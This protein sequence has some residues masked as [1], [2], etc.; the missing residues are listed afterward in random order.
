MRLKRSILTLTLLE[1]FIHFVKGSTKA[2][3]LHDQR[4]IFRK[5]LDT[6]VTD[7]SSLILN[8]NSLYQTLANLTSNVVVNITTN[9]TL[10]T[11]VQLEDLEN[12]SIIGH[13]KPFIEC[14][15][16][17]G[18]LHFTSC[19]NCTIEGIIWKNCGHVIGNKTY[20]VLA[21]YKS[22]TVTIQD[23]SFENSAAQAVTLSEVSGNITVANCKFGYNY[24][25]IYKGHG[26]AVYY[27]KG[28]E[29]HL[30]FTI[31][32][33]DFAHFGNV[34]SVVYIGRS[35]SDTN[36]TFLLHNSTFISNRGVPIYFLN[37]TL[38]ISGT[39]I[40]KRNINGGIFAS[41]SNIMIDENSKVIFYNNVAKNGGAI[42]LQNHSLI[43]FKN[44]S[45]VQ[46]N[47]NFA[48]INGGAI[49]AYNESK[50]ILEG[51]SQVTFDNNVAV[52]G[53]GGAVFAM[54]RVNITFTGNCS[55]LFTNNK[56]VADSK[57]ARNGGAITLK[58]HSSITFEGHCD[59][60]LI[61]NSAKGSGGAI[62]SSNSSC[63]TFQ[64]KSTVRFHLNEAKQG[65]AMLSSFSS[66]IKF[67][68]NTLVIYSAN[69]AA[70]SNSVIHTVYNA[71]DTLNENTTISESA[72]A[73]HLQ[74][75]C[76]ITFEGK[77]LV[78][79]SYHKAVYG[80]T[81]YAYNNS[82]VT[83]KGNATVVFDYNEAEFGGAIYANRN[84]DISI[85][86]KSV[87]FI[88]N[89]ATQDGGALYSHDACDITFKGKAMVI[90]TLDK[91]T[92]NGGVGYF[93][94]SCH[95]IFEGNTT[96]RFDN[97]EAT[98]EAGVLYAAE[99][100]VEF[101]EN[102]NIV[103]DN[104][105]AILSGGALYFTNISN[106]SF[107]ENSNTTFSNNRATFNGGA[108]YFSN[109]SL[110]S[111]SDTSQVMFYHNDAL[112]GGAVCYNNN[113]SIEFKDSSAVTFIGN[114]ATVSGGAIQ[115]LSNSDITLTSNNTIIFTNNTAQYGGAIFFD[116]TQSSMIFSNIQKKTITFINNNAR[117]IGNS[118]Y[119]DLMKSCNSSCLANRIVGINI[120]NISFIAT[121][122]SKLMLYDPAICIDDDNDSDC[123][124]YYL[125]N[126]MF[127][128]DIVVPT[129][130]LD[131]YNQK[132]VD[133][134]QFLVRG[135]MNQN[136]FIKGPNEVL[137]S[138]D[139]FK[140]ISIFGNKS[141]SRSTNHT[142]TI[143]LNVD[144]NS[145]WKIISVNLIVELS[146]CHPGFQ[147]DKKLQECE[148]YNASDIVL[149]SGSTSSIKGG[150]WFGS[151]TG[152]PTVTFC[153]INYCNFS[154]CDTANGFYHLSPLRDN[155][156][157]SRRSG[158]AC[159]SCTDGY[160]LSFDSTD[161]VPVN[162]CTAGHTILIVT[163]TLI[164]WIA[165]V[166]IVFV[167]MHYKVSIGYLYAVTF[168]YSIVDILLSQ[169][170]YVS[171][172][173]FMTVNIM[174]STAKLTPQFL[175]QLCLAKD[176]S[177]ID[178]QV[179]HYIH[180]LAVSFILLIISFL[181]RCSYRLSAFIS[182]E[183]I[184]VICFL[185]L[186]SYTSLA[187]TSLMLL[188]SLTFVDVDTVYTYLSPDIE[189][190]HGRHLVYAIT[191]ILFMIS[192][193]AGLPLLLSLEPFVNG[194]INFTKI[195][196]L[197]DQFQ[198]CYKDRYRCFAG[199]YMICRLVIILII[200]SNSSSYFSNQYLL[201]ATCSMIALL[202]L[203]VR[204]Y[205]DNMLNVLDGIVLQLLV[206]ITALPLLDTYNSNTGLGITFTL[207]VSPVLS[208]L[209]VTLV[210]RRED[211]KKIVIYCDC[212][213]INT[214]NNPE[215]PASTN[216][217]DDN[218]VIKRTKTATNDM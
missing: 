148:C 60:N 202:H 131:Y 6:K 217:L 171:P 103:F 123:G 211:I 118:V 155:Q 65:G 22:V 157:R 97:N 5:K 43:I 89:T 130:V 80:G 127:G 40:F 205:A 121:P 203:T 140:G 180:P 45:V 32:N 192:I 112:Y 107:S 95:V 58:L 172:A 163:I 15:N 207:V 83:V 156:C 143:T 150:Y 116:A 11:V 173:L 212:K 160:T 37:Q 57:N 75:Y 12:V 126:I 166:I 125:Q 154:C 64:G 39:V 175:G 189:Y 106:I 190:F 14:H 122:P 179:I 28:K 209:I 195:K 132:V 206:L 76:N 105:K 20:P 30:M 25:G 204:P 213:F 120:N 48:Y 78:T 101:K 146:P 88:G 21:L 197:L 108:L 177:G 115:A 79:F 187:T 51:N 91:A 201:S 169:N 199:Y 170:L 194:K 63:I 165:V 159:G 24:N 70:L 35:T 161:C 100:N 1:I 90:F 31:S 10:L 59:V 44:S 147:Y 119:F 110:I 134:T 176:M 61:S 186:L 52:T 46:L 133:T 104:N 56:A 4:N 53:S 196:P 99:S 142:I 9:M 42:N 7:Q 19:Y 111:F 178:Q 162:N 82:H 144:H 102:S 124:T 3:E 158:V 27:N 38:V 167:M 182:R 34:E 174:S 152:K 86:G 84:S 208:L 137:I 200:I 8:D 129:C 216:R 184:P 215:I 55:V 128:Q 71:D 50:I 23:C 33:C 139:T 81:V 214:K 74:H 69:T 67:K 2:T 109:N 26:A 62:C 94:K 183:I 191:A 188:R 87:S 198:G 92:R 151:V 149:C 153:P 41:N 193:V 136:L 114:T 73:V 66:S 117:I 18:Q 16:V 113:T 135:E 96:V 181:A 168:Y 54:A 77:S 13:N 47:N 210:V 85:A 93:N 49:Y 98:M 164:Y 36:K 17:G 138:C 185:L 68:E 218:R 145:D 141:L 72:G 29:S